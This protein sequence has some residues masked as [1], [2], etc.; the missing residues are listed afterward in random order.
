MEGRPVAHVAKE[1]GI[2]RQCAHRWV[3]RYRAEGEA[4]WGP[5]S[6]PHR[7][8]RRT[9]ADVE[10]GVLS[11]DATSGAVRTG[12]APSWASRH[13]RS[14]RSCTA[15]RCP[16]ARLRPADRRGDPGLQ[17]HDPALR[18]GRTGDLI[19]IDVKK[20]GRIPD[21]GGWRAHGR[22]E[23]GPRPR[24]RLRLR[25]RRRR[26]PLPLRL[27]RGPQRRDR[28]DLCQLR[29]AAALVFLSHG[30]TVREVITDNARNYTDSP[31]SKP[32][33]ARSAHAT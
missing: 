17:D 11:C 4:G 20:L 2:S 16:P 24:D 31:T 26:R 13:G 28:P 15:T 33:S 14:R 19:H 29:P 21:G 7:R 1:L 8:P 3:A 30:I 27:R 18:T 6:R 23:R 22:S 10:Q 9:P 32:P 25:P 5:S 12:S